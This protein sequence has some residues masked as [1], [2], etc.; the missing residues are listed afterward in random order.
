MSE[1]QR[2]GARRRSPKAGS[3]ATRQKAASPNSKPRGSDLERLTESVEAQRRDLDALTE[4]VESLLEIEERI[5][6]RIYDL[7]H[8]VDGLLERGPET[9]EAPDAEDGEEPTYGDLVRR[10]REQVREALPPDATVIVVSKGDEEMLDLY[11][12]TTWHFPQDRDGEYLW[13]YPPDGPGPIV[14]LEALRVRG[15]QYLLFPQPSLWWLDRYPRFADHLNRHYRVIVRDES[16]VIFTLDKKYL[17]ADPGAWR[18]RISQ[19]IDECADSV[20]KDPSILDFNSGLDLTERF[21]RQAV[22]EPPRAGE[23]R[24]PYIDRSID[25]VVLSSSSD[26]EAATEARRVAGHAVVTVTLPELEG[27]EESENATDLDPSIDP[28]PPEEIE[29]EVE[30]EAV[31]LEGVEIEVDVERV[32]GAKGSELPS[33]SIVIPTYNGVEQLRTCLRSLDETLPNPFDGEVIVVDDG[34]G[35]EMRDLLDKWRGS[36]INLEIVRNPKNRGFVA[37]CNR[38]ASVAKNDMLIFLNDD[39]ITQDGWVQALLR[40]FRE[41]PDAGAVGGRL[42]YPDGRLQE[43]GSLVFSDASAANVGRDDYAIEDPLYNHVRQ[44]DYCSAALLATP[45][46]LFSQIGGFDKRFEPGYYED[47]DYCFEVRKHGSRVYYQPESVVI[48]VEGATGGTDLT[49]GA[50]RYQVVN[51]KKFERKWRQTLRKQPERPQP[52]DKSAFYQL[53]QRSR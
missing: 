29:S 21:A 16:C 33:V 37:S 8:S 10:M 46:S 40:T 26:K 23:S 44:V 14:H 39:T 22:L 45:R 53:A 42:L 47:T 28:L 43:A 3:A 38:G 27:E 36:R 15:G 18:A 51:H 6:E 25:I 49:A 17:P 50:K 20:G 48:H 9:E 52:L 34:S 19:V 2:A 35:Q 11:G 30:D 1:S 31:D 12:R 24:L 32:N 13:Y 4:R 5:Y 41:Y 7:R